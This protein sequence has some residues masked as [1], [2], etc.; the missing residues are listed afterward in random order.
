MTVEEYAKTLENYYKERGIEANA[1]EEAKKKL[2]AVEVVKVS[3]GEVVV[4]TER[5]REDGAVVVRYHRINPKRK[6]CSCEWYAKH[7]VCK[8]VV[9]ILLLKEK[10]PS[11]LRRKLNFPA[12]KANRRKKS[13]R[14]EAPASL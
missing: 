1:L 9:K 14:R 7:G 8:H 10:G 2:E 4:R 12:Y 13:L 6:S 11:Y 3:P 5:K